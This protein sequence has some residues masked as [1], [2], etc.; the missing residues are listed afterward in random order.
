MNTKQLRQKILDLAIRGKLVP[1]DPND[2]PASVLLERI[3]AEKERLIKEG[4]IKRPKKS[5]TT[6]DKPHYEITYSL[7]NNWEVVSIDD[8]ALLLSGR[9]LNADECNEN[10]YGLPYLIGASNIINGQMAFIRWTTC[11]KVISEKSDILISCKGTIGETVI[12]N[13]GEIHIARQFMAIRSLSNVILSDYFYLAIKAVIEEIRNSARGIIPG[14]SREDILFR[15]IGIPPLNEQIRIVKEQKRLFHIIDALEVSSKE[16]SNTLSQ[17]KSKILE[18]AICGKLVPQDPADEPA[19]EL[20]RR[21]NPSAVPADKSH[22]QHL[23][24][25]WCMTSMNYICQLYDGERQ[26]GDK[27]NLDAKFLRGRS[28]GTN[29]NSGRFVPKNTTMILVDGENSGEIF[30]APIDGYQG[31]TFKLLNISDEMNVE[32][33]KIIIRIYQKRLRDNKVGSA[34]PHLNK[35]MFKAIEVPVP[36]IKE[37]ARIVEKVFTLF[38]QIETLSECL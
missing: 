35:K 31:S 24:N 16:I 23:P 8:I 20:L 19:E 13:I 21:I 17:V 2:E 37:Q 9:D 32:Y 22:Y 3:K 10:G 4:K 28:E 34:I 33:V 30:T 5:A 26:T 29:L 36:P 12:N 38:S 7:P 6:A 25:G 27:I 18:L 15:K 11:P 14:I 1:Q